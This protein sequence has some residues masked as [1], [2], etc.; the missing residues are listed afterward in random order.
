MTEKSHVKRKMQIWRYVL[1]IENLIFFILI[2]R[3]HAIKP[4]KEMCLPL[5]HAVDGQRMIALG[6]I[7]YDK[8]FVSWLP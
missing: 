1:K 7:D 3:E 6:K 4:F 2:K 5:T 8:I